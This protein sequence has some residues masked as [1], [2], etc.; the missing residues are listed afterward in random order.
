[1]Q[2]VLILGHKNVSQIILLCQKLCPCFNVYI[3]FDK[4]LQVTKKEQQQLKSLGVHYISKYDVKWGGFTIGLATIELMKMA[5]LNPHNN[6]FHLVSGQDWPMKS[7]Q[8]I[9]NFFQNKN[10]IFMDYFRADKT[11]KAGEPL[12][13]WAKLYFNYDHLPINRKSFIGK[14]YHRLLLLIQLTCRINKLKKYNIPESKIYYGQNWVDIPRDAL[15]FA[16]SKYEEDKNLQKIFATSFCADE[17]WLQTILCNSK[18]SSRIDKRIY[19]YIV[20]ER[21]NGSYPAILDESDFDKIVS[22]DYFWGRKIEF[23]YSKRL[24]ELLNNN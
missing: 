13:W 21:K 7:P 19:R 9:Y 8:D 12:I 16:I 3:H 20:W 18:Y 2:A 6:Y 11:K 24:V 17:M 23:P 4:K 1:M 10:S 15:E 5:L 14:I 22:G